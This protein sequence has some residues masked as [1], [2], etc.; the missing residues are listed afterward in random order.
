MKVTTKG[1]VTI[2][3]TIREKLGITPDTEVDFMQEGDRVVIVKR[4]DA[5]PASQKFKKL[6]GIA[7]VKMT[8]DEIMALTR[9]V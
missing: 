3:V 5:T 4:K 9:D 8:T 2:P 6:R 7:T 1:Q